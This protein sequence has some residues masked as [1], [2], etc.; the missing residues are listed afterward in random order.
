MSHGTEQAGYPT[1]SLFEIACSSSWS[2]D[3]PAQQAA[4]LDVRHDQLQHC[5]VPAA[6]LIEKSTLLLSLSYSPPYNAP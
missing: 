1:Q 5:D 4:D 6:D 3:L 2:T